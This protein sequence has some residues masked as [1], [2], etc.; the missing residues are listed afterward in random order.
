MDKAPRN[1]QETF[2]HVEL[3]VSLTVVLFDFGTRVVA[4]HDIEIL[5]LASDYKQ[6]LVDEPLLDDVVGLPVS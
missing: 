5:L 3:R 4:R 1:M 6:V 2:L